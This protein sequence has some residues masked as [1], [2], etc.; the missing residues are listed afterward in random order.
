VNLTVLLKS[1]GFKLNF[2]DFVKPSPDAMQKEK[3][4]ETVSIDIKCNKSGLL[5]KLSFDMA[6]CNCP[7]EGGEHDS[8]FWEVQGTSPKLMKSKVS[9]IGNI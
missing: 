8:A 2:L 7:V 3:N 4:E 9:F 5:S 6:H 1:L